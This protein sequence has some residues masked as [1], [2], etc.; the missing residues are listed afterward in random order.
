MAFN[1]D[2]TKAMVYAAW[3]NQ[4]QLSA[5]ELR[6]GRWVGATNASICIWIA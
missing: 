3:R 2:K 1:A 4:G 6:D 5:L